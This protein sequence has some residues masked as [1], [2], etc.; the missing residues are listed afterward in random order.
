MHNNHEDDRLYNDIH[1]GM[2]VFNM[3]EFNAKVS[4]NVDSM[5]QR[6]KQLSV[7]PTKEEKLENPRT[8]ISIEQHSSVKLDDLSEW[9]YISVYQAQMTLNVT[10]RKLKISEP[11]PLSEDTE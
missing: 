6:I 7:G 8:F 3:I 9:W 1:S 2:G 11:M 4:S 10:T 5:N